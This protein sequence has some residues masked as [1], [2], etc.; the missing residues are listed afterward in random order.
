MTT[1][2]YPR[3]KV[4]L[5]GWLDRERE[6]DRKR[7]EHSEDDPSGIGRVDTRTIRNAARGAITRY[8]LQV[9]APDGEPFAIPITIHRGVPGSELLRTA[10]PDDFVVVEGYMKLDRA[11]DPRY[12]VHALDEGR[13]Y[14]EMTIYATDVRVRSSEETFTGSGAWVDGIVTEPPIFIRDPDAPERF[15]ARTT[16]RTR[17][18]YSPEP[19]LLPV[20][21]RISE[22][23]VVVATDT[24]DADLLFRAGNHV[25]VSG[26]I[27]RLLTRQFGRVIRDKMDALDDE[28]AQIEATHS[29][30]PDEVR[31][32]GRQHLRQRQ[33]LL[34]A[35]RPVVLVSTVVGVDGAEPL[36]MIEARTARRTHVREIGR[37]RRERAQRRNQRQPVQTDDVGDDGGAESDPDD[38]TP[39]PVEQVRHRKQVAED[40]E[41]ENGSHVSILTDAPESAEP[42]PSGDQI[43]LPAE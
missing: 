32:R 12:A 16:I 20:V 27:T 23:P 15:L 39:P 1:P 26:P 34:Q 17:I 19:D 24:P 28:W 7:R 8:T 42:S 25:Q 22:V 14:R 41:G 9:P 37:Q 13:V 5:Y 33:R 10:Q 11:V 38:H 40:G 36:T 18:A 2:A 21:E 43:N 4:I 6:R 29:N 31:K 35:A 3:N 30:N